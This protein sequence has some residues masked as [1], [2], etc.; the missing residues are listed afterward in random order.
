[1]GCIYK[2]TNNVN[3]MIYIGKITDIK[4]QIKLNGNYVF[5][6]NKEE[7]IAVLNKLIDKKSKQNK[8]SK[9]VVE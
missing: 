5:Y 4:R 1:M 3:N 8:V 2:I 6:Q 9:K 7:R